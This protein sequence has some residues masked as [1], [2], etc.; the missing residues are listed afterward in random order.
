MRGVRPPRFGF[1][2]SEGSDH[3]TPGFLFRTRKNYPCFFFSWRGQTTAIF[4][5]LNFPC[6][7][8]AHARVPPRPHPQLHWSS[9][10]VLAYLFFNSISWV[11]FAQTDLEPALS[12]L[13]LEA[14]LLH[15]SPVLLCRWTSV[16]QL[17]P[18]RS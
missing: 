6:C 17:C 13:H 16:G 14:P 5:F 18:Q 3:L 7:T 11:S 1:I 15:H 8:C 12:Q 10:K 4:P 9:P 2:V